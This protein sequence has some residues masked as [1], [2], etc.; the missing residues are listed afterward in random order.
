MAGVMRWL[1]PAIALALLLA[2]LVLS[3]SIWPQAAETMGRAAL[4]GGL[5]NAR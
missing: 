1:V 4:A 5:M 2:L 3:V